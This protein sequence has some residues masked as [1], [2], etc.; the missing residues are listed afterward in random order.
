MAWVRPT[1][2]WAMAAVV[3][4]TGPPSPMFSP[5]AVQCTPAAASRAPRS[6]SPGHWWESPQ[7]PAIVELCVDALEFRPAV[8]VS[9][10]RPAAERAW[11][12]SARTWAAAL[13]EVV[14]AGLVADAAGEG[15]AGRADADAVGDGAG[16]WC[17]V[18][19]ADGLGESE[20][21]TLAWKGCPA[22]APADVPVDGS[23]VAGARGAAVIFPV[24]DAGG[25]V[26]PGGRLT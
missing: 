21:G 25:G 16:R 13:P 26:G 4:A 1:A 5:A 17:L 12:M 14:P 19:A 2:I 15:E 7:R 6:G 9:G 3:S 23:H 11:L 8:I 22:Q 20:A 18:R 10:A 24:A